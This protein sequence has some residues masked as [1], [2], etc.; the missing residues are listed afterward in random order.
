MKPVMKFGPLVAVAIFAMALLG[1]SLAMGESTELCEAD[2]SPCASPVAHV[3]YVAEDSFILGIY[4]YHCDV[5]FLAIVGEL[6]SPQALEGKLTYD[7]SRRR[8]V[9]FDSY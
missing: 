8:T 2:E 3:H 7:R 9:I 5:L 6:G 1:P 4:N